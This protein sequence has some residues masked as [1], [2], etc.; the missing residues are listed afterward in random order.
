MSL[1]LSVVVS[2]RN[3][4]AH[5]IECAKTI[6][7]SR[8]PAEV[9]FI[10]QSDDDATEKGLSVIAD[11]RLRY[12]R[13]DSRGVT[14]GRNLG[15]EL[16]SGDIIAIT[17]DD[18]RV[19]PDWAQRILDVFEQDQDVAV[20]CGR[21]CVPDH[22]K[23]LGHTESFEPVVREWR[24]RYPPLGRDWGIGANF[25]IRRSVLEQVGSF[26]PI[27]GPGGALRAA[28]GEEYDFLFRVLKAGFTV[29][30]ATEVVADHYGYRKPGEESRK[31][32]VGY[33]TGTAAAIFKHVRLAD[34]AGIRLYVQFLAASIA[35]VITRLAHG[36]RPTGVNY[37]RAFIAGTLASYR[38]RIDP[39]RRLYQER[40]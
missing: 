31:L 18:C 4:A 39:M 37:L 27:L 29:V 13:T 20:V 28:G 16:S 23:P 32:I 21:V 10:D 24:R 35:V 17:D 3:R 30:N 8:V 34:P 14:K 25:S 19:S 40:R 33:G 26:D 2:T 1:A 15:F 38:F 9:L 12:I 7:Q 5:A 36:T 11:P 6:L 22:I